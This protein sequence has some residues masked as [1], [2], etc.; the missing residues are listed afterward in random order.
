MFYSTGNKRD[1][2]SAVRDT[3]HPGLSLI[4]S[5]GTLKEKTHLKL[6]GG[7]L[8]EGVVGIGFE[9]EV[10]Q[11]VDDGVDRQ[12]GLPVLAEDVQT[13]VAL[14]VDVRMVNLLKI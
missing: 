7:F 4:S 11:S 6:V 10:L 8:V 9:E 14:Q 3:S 1:R 12:D 13:D 2:R 5:M